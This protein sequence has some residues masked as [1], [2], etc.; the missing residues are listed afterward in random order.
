MKLV[1]EH[2]DIEKAIYGYLK[3]VLNLEV[4]TDSKI[5]ITCKKKH[6]TAHVTGTTPS[7]KPVVKETITSVVKDEPIGISPPKTGPLPLDKA[8]DAHRDKIDWSSQAIMSSDLSSLGRGDPSDF[9]DEISGN[10]T[11]FA[12]RGNNGS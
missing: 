7:T 4:E 11:A 12:Y 10:A 2:A 5:E 8:L 1:L 9:L 6:L 3:N